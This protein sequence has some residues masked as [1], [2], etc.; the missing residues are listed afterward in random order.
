MS[1]GGKGRM[2]FGYFH[3]RETLLGDEKVVQ[4]GTVAQTEN[5]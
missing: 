1:S 3:R 4:T 2:T 5:M